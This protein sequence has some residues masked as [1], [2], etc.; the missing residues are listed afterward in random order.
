MRPSATQTATATSAPSTTARLARRTTSVVT[1]DLFP[2][3]ATTPA[4]TVI[5]ASARRCRCGGTGVV[6][7]PAA[8]TPEHPAVRAH[9]VAVAKIGLRLRLAHRHSRGGARDDEVAGLQRHQPTDVA[10]QLGDGEEHVPGGA[11]LPGRVVDHEA[12]PDVGGVAEL[13]G[14]DQPR[15]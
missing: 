1:P 12:Q 8:V 13:V 15:P 9:D 6:H 4:M 14:R 7:N 11:V 5:P 3:L 10:Q 2:E